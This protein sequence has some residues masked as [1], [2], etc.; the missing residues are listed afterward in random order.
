MQAVLE[1]VEF[2]SQ[3]EEEEEEN[4]MSEEAERCYQDQ[5]NKLQDE[6]PVQ[7][8]QPEAMSCSSFVNLNFET[9]GDCQSIV[10]SKQ[11]LTP[12]PT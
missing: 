11:D 8:D 9:E 4:K 5:Q 2:F 7:T 12:V 3:E 6:T 1:P 10:E